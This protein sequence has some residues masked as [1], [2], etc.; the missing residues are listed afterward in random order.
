[1]HSPLVT[2]HICINL[3][4]NRQN[5][6]LFI[7]KIFLP[8]FNIAIATFVIFL[9]NTSMLN[10]IQISE[11]KKVNEECLF[12]QVFYLCKVL[13]STKCIYFELKGLFNAFLT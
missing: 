10:D 7:F 13:K 8:S 5:D 4:E 1:M 11:K 9:E 12:N 6:V 2:F 3:D